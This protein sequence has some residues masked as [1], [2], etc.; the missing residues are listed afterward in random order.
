M[1]REAQ[2]RFCER[3]G[4]RFPPP[5]LLVLMVFGTRG[6]AE[7]LREEVADVLAPIGLRLSE[8]KTSV[9]HLDEGFTSSG[10]VSSGNVNEE[11]I[12]AS[13]IPSSRISPSLPSGGR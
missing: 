10:S 4:A 11:V 1:S 7:A 13:F 9:C 12:S 6:H 3:R 2:V 8:A 5:T